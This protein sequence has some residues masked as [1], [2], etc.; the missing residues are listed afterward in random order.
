MRDIETIDSELRLLLAIRQM[1]REEEGR[2]PSAA[3]VEQLLICS[4]SGRRR[5]ATPKGAP[6]GPRPP[7]RRSGARVARSGS[8]P[9][10][11]W[12]GPD[13]GMQESGIREEVRDPLSRT[14][15][16]VFTS[17]SRESQS[18]LVDDAS[19]SQDLY[20]FAVELR[21]LAYTM[22]AGYENPLIHLSERMVR[23]ARNRPAEQPR[24]EGL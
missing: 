9:Q 15:F 8:R 17:P 3:A 6:P 2:T 18:H 10:W 5:R 24:K 19:L 1:V 16:R 13:R 21:Q 7:A 11:V 14:A 4:T 22:P 20:K 12:A 23:C